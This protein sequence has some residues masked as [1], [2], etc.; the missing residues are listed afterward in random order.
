MNRT[1]I[2]KTQWE[3]L[4][5]EPSYQGNMS[6]PLRIWAPGIFSASSCLCFLGIRVPPD[7]NVDVVICFQKSK[8]KIHG[9]TVMYR[10]LHE[11]CILIARLICFW[12]KYDR[13]VL[14]M[15]TMVS[16]QS[17][18]GSMRQMV[19]TTLVMAISEQHVDMKFKCIGYLDPRKCIL[20][21]ANACFR[22]PWVTTLV[23]C[24]Y[25]LQSHS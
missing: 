1:T 6:G 19:W 24:I 5:P 13:C 14:Y 7:A 8:Q 25:W 16:W 3:W 23:E 18:Y 21:D 4:E 9:L 22:W 11:W 10:V 17:L 20:N 2:S 12:M 15:F